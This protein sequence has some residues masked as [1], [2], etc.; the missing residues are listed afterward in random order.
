[1]NDSRQEPATSD[2][3]TRIELPS[4]RGG[5][6]FVL[7]VVVVA[8]AGYVAF[9]LRRGKPGE[10]LK[11]SHV[12]AHADEETALAQL[13]SEKQEPLTF[14]KTARG[15]DIHRSQQAQLDPR[16]DGWETE[17]LADQARSRLEEI[18]R[19]P[20]GERSVAPE[21]SRKVVP[22]FT[23]G[24]LRPALIDVFR[25]ASVVVR[26]PSVTKQRPVTTHQGGQGLAE[27]LA[28]FAE[29][30]IDAS[31]VHLH[32]KVVRVIETPAA[33]NTTAIVEASGRTPT[34]SVEQHVT[35]SCAWVRDGGLLRLS[36]IG[37]HDYEEVI[38]TSPSGTW[39]SDCTEAVLKKNASFNAQ[40]VHGLNHWL[41]RVD[42]VQGIHVFARWGLAVGDCNGDGL[43]DIYVCQPGGLPNRLF[44]QNQDG[45]ATDVSH[46]SG[47]DWLDHTSS[48]LFVD[49]DND[50][51]QDLIVA[52]MSGL[53]VMEN[54]STGRFR[55][56]ATLPPAD[57]DL[58]S[59]S[60]ADYDNDGD[61]D[62]YVC[63]D[64]ANLQSLHGKRSV[65]F[66]YH[67]AN[68]GG[69][70]V[71]FRNDIV[72]A[73]D[74][75]WKFSD[76]TRETGLDVHN[77][78]HSLAA[79]WEDYDN[80]G[81]QD[82][83]VANDYGQ[84]CLYRNDGGRFAD[85]ATTAKVVDFGSGMSVSWADYNR[86]GWMDLYVGNMFSSAGNRITRQAAFKASADA[87]VRA[88]YSR[89]AKGNSLFQNL[90]KTDELSA[91]GFRE[92]GTES[93]VEMARWAWS[94]V[95]ADVN[96]DGW[97]DL[98]VANGYITTEDSGDL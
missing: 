11:S 4:I 9:H 23:C 10:T 51:D 93:A 5:A 69:A 89:F 43:D 67:D 7:L 21:L 35:W 20:V 66:V 78:R 45:T 17:V 53:L 28:E 87:T 13:N 39:F 30:R 54:D 55:R 57:V 40:L 60:A 37:L 81:D 64:F 98:I 41:T 36:S 94:S 83:Y 47:V 38:T 77:R 76:V 92:V 42:R 25:D 73:A 95:F 71:L 16:Q 49:I 58:Q 24:R 62:L 88:V 6:F 74:G 85:V 91:V 12:N 1:M 61:L 34:G 86:D 46:E 97:E 32:V 79:S 31:D 15:R 19:V 27:A 3:E 68:D 8:V 65:G 96:N 90:G 52:T 63:V 70:N 14:I 56:R 18:L 26:R 44:R 50:E 82:L 2:G 33:I 22:E 29:P 72:T 80:D 75:K 59:L 48:A 84:N